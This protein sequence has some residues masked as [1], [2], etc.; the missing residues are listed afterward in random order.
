MS[1]TSTGFHR[2]K[3]TAMRTLSRCV[4]LGLNVVLAAALIVLVAGCPGATPPKPASPG[5]GKDHVGKGEGKTDVGKSDMARTGEKGDKGE[6]GDRGERGGDRPEKG[7]KRDKGDGGTAKDGPRSREAP[8]EPVVGRP[9]HEA[10]KPHARE[11]PHAGL[12]TAGSWDD[13][14]NPPFFR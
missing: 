7:D 14:L 5:S 10:P 12:L 8:V 3:E 6:K 1:R 13:N 4:V 9:R 11:E 2:S